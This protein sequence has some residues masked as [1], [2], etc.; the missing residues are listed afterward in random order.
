MLTFIICAII[1]TPAIIYAV[2]ETHYCLF[3]E[4]TD[5]DTE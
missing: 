5:R 2:R 3:I 4:G 1:L